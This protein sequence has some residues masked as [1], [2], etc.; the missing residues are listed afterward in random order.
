[1]DSNKDKN[2]VRWVAWYFVDAVI[3]FE[4]CWISILKSV[5]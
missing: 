3:S 4:M 2:L 1:M 5:I